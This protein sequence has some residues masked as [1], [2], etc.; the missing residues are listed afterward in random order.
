MAEMTTRARV[1]AALRG[2]P[3]DRVPISLWLHNFAAENSAAELSAETLRLAR[4][5]QFDFLKPQTRAQCFA[6]AWGLRYQPSTR[7]AEKFTV[8]QYPLRGAADFARL[9]P[10][11]PLSGALGEQLQALEQIRAGV[12]PDTPIIW[13]V[14]APIMTA[15]YLVP[16]DEAQ[17]LELARSEPAALA[18]GLEAITETLAGYARAAL[19]RGADGIFYATT[20]ARAGQLT[21]EE[22]RRFQRPYDLPI[23]EAVQ[24]ASFNL[25]HVCGERVWFDE[26]IDYPVHAFSWA[27]GAG[28]PTLSEGHRRTGRAVVGG[29]PGKPVF[30]QL[31]PGELAAR[32]RAAIAELNGRWLLLG[33][34]CSINPDTP[35]ENIQAA[36]DA[37]RATPVG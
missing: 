35:E 34:D 1:L 33:P 4:R 20:A 5:F 2:E 36:V 7:P 6:E 12:G 3:V 25:L 23:L 11:D 27:Q 17:I 19:E 30:G 26:F 14:F 21:A 29:L 18:K 16:G 37:A 10:A 31:A 22:C 13:T 8:T 32:A 15:R 9:R 28:N 24:R